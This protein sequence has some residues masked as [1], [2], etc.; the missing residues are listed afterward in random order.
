MYVCLYQYVCLFQFYSA[1]YT[2]LSLQ[3][4]TDQI[5][6]NMHKS[7]GQQWKVSRTVVDAKCSQHG[8]ALFEHSYIKHFWQDNIWRYMIIII[9]NTQS[10]HNV[11]HI[12]Q[13]LTVY[14]SLLSFYISVSQSIIW[15][16]FFILN[17]Y[18]GPQ[19]EPWLTK[20][21]FGIVGS[22]LSA[23]DLV[24]V[25]YYTTVIEPITILQAKLTL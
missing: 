14:T 8:L 4:Q 13:S 5:K 7:L 2:L 19:V 25:V 18:F 17:M 21:L 12:I 9:L 6:A 20:P 24:S 1:L 23:Q 3:I 11:A 15:D 22:Q 16:Y 10:L